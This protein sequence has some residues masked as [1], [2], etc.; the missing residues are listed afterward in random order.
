M[1]TTYILEDHLGG[2][3]S[4]CR[5][6]IG[7]PSAPPATQTAILLSAFEDPAP[8]LN[9]GV[10]ADIEIGFSYSSRDNAYSVMRRLGRLL[11]DSPG[12]I[13]S[14][15]AL[16]LATIARHGAKQ[17]VFQIV[18]DEFNLRLAKQFAQA[19]DVF[20]AHSLFF[21]RRLLEEIP[22][23]ASN[24]YHLPYGIRLSDRVRRPRPGPLRLTFLGRLT[25]AKGALDLPRIDDA[26][27]SAGVRVEWTI[28]GDGEARERLAAEMPA[29]GN[30]RYA[31]PDTT[32][33][34]LVCCAAADVLVFPT[35]FEGFPVALL[36]A[37]SAGLVPIVSDLPSGIPEV[38]DDGV[39]GFR[40]PVG[41][42][43]GFAGAVIALDRD[44]DRLEAMSREAHQR[45]QAFDVHKRAGAYHELFARAGELKHPGRGRIRMKHGS[46]LDHPLL[47]NSIVRLARSRLR[48]L[49]RTGQDP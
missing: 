38:V 7:S 11:P 28:I 25:E 16:E 32:D 42:I 14:N 15:S 34:V 1:E 33:E 45:A 30:V 21:Y 22:A 23:R 8:K 9:G 40:V 43:Q 29:S 13:V 20:I 2:I 48:P 3:A 37:M 47:P 4:F 27:R 19:V 5:N 44:R 49:A 17:T 26:L 10:G 18:H 24:T 39:S 12:A 6:L 36:E 41:D 46:R 35:R 31:T